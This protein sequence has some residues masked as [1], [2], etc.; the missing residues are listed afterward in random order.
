M[1][2]NPF[3]CGIIATILTELVLL[4]GTVIYMNAKEKHK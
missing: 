4:V 1:Y 3:W 2:I